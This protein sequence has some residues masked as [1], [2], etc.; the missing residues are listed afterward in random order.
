MTGRPSVLVI[1]TDQLHHP[2]PY[3][4]DELAAFRR[5]HLHGVERLREN[6]VSRA[7]DRQRPPSR[8]GGEPRA[9]PSPAT[10][11]DC[12]FGRKAVAAYGQP[13]DRHRDRRQR[14]RHLSETRELLR[15]L[16]LG[17]CFAW[18]AV[19]RRDARGARGVRRK[20]QRVFIAPISVA[21]GTMAT[22][23]ATL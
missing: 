3:E 14:Q 11:R 6:G 7:C 8:N 20:E 10:S 12:C 13:L 2:P 19:V 22:V 23:P 21:A 16:A 4:S 17:Y 1:L 5:E 9:A 15:G 18:E